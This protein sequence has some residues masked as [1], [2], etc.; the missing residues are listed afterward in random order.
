M[1]TRPH[2]NLLFVAGVALLVG[3]GCSHQRAEAPPAEP[4]LLVAT[5]PPDAPDPAEKTY[6]PVDLR[7]ASS[8][9]SGVAEVVL[10][11]TPRVDVPNA[12]ARLVLPEGVALVSGAPEVELGPLAKGARASLAVRVQI[13]LQGAFTLAG[14][15]EVELSPARKLA[16]SMV[17]EV[18]EASKPTAPSVIQLPEGGSVRVQ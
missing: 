11:V 16:R 18:G 3:S 6:A 8:A 12:R 14:G 7:L 4:E 5:T 13:P 1:K 2:H 15:V 17:L 9:R 10:T